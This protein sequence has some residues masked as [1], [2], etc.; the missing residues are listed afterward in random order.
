MQSLLS[1]GADPEMRSGQTHPIHTL[2]T[3]H[4]TYQFYSVELLELTHFSGVVKLDCVCSKCFFWW[5]CKFHFPCL[6]HRDG[7]GQTTLHLLITS[8]PSD[9]TTWQKPGSKLFNEAE[10]CLR[11][12]CEHGVN[13]NAEVKLFHIAKSMFSL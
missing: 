7:L 5:I 4:P 3:K 12:L 2:H 13:V 8:W 10:A 6:C 1:A 9:K 11:L